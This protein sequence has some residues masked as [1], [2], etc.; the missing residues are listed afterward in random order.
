MEEMTIYIPK[1]ELQRAAGKYY[2]KVLKELQTEGLI[3]STE[4]VVAVV[5][6]KS[7]ATH[8]QTILAFHDVKNFTVQGLS[9]KRKE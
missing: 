9:P 7:I 4:D 8:F 3:L 2:K 5:F 1:E 6:N